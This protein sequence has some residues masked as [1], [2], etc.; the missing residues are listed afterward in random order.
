MLVVL[1]V[2]LV[3]VVELVVLGAAVAGVADV[4]AI[5]AMVVVDS[6]IGAIICWLSSCWLSGTGVTDT[7]PVIGVASVG[8]SSALRWDSVAVPLAE[9]KALG[10]LAAVTVG[11]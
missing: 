1:V 2:S 6:S 11:S 4:D 3:G 7:R 5:G 9:T 10:S 8:V